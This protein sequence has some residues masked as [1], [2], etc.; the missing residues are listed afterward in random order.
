[1]AT[2]P[3]TGGCLCQGVQFE[4]SEPLHGALYCHCK[5]CQ[6]RTG[7]AFS[8]SALTVPGSFTITRGE[9]LVRSWQPADGWGKAFCAECGGHL[10]STDPKNPELVAVRMGALDDDP[11][12]RP[13]FH[14][15][16]DYAAP[17][18]ALPDDGLR[19]YGERVPADV[20]QAT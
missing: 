11:G 7:T 14:Q 17:W 10:F 2:M 20:R 4:V 9:D 19:R 3:L 6:R 13:S 18:D 15:F 8:A 1:M 12:I 5:R 16:V